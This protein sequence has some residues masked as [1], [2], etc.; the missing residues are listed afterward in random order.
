[1]LYLSLPNAK[2]RVGFESVDSDLNDLIFSEKIKNYL[3]F[4]MELIKYLKLIK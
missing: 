1:M 3:D 4:K 2:F